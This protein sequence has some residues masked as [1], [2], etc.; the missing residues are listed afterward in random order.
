MDGL[1]DRIRME[2]FMQINRIIT[3][4]G[5]LGT[6]KPGLGTRLQILK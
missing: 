4:A 3:V 5:K 2:A 6:L 1:E